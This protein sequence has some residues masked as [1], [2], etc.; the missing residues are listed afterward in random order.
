[1][2]NKMRDRKRIIR[3][4]SLILIAWHKNCDLRLCQLIGNCFESGDNYY[5]EDEEL[6]KRIKEMYDV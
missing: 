2:R 4:L 6:E 1:M 5:K 3:I